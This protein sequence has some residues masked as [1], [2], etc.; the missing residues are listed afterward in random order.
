M[1]KYYVVEFASEDSASIAAGFDVCLA[2]VS[3]DFPLCIIASELTPQLE[4]L[5]RFGEVKIYQR[6][7]LSVEEK[8]RWREKQYYLKF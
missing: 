7:A 4:S 6:E 8:E 1:N 5:R 3:C 2:L